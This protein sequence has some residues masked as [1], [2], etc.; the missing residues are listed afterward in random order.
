MIY[1]LNIDA[2]ITPAIEIIIIAAV[3]NIIVSM[4]LSRA[5][6]C[7]YR[8]EQTCSWVVSLASVEL[9]VVMIS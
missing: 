4:R 7:S 6:I 3:F 2:Q 5:F 8:N 1:P 9:I